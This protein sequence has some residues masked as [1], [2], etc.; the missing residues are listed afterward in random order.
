GLYAEQFAAS[1]GNGDWKTMDEDLGNYYFR[2]YLQL[3]KEAAPEIVSK[4][5]SKLYLDKRK[6]DIDA[7]NNAFTLQSL[8]SLHLVAADGNTSA[9]QTVRIFLIVGI[10]ILCIACIN[11]VN[12]STARSMLRSK[13]VSMRKIIGAARA[14]LFL[15]FIIESV[16]LFIFASALSLLIIYLLL[17]LYNQVSGRQLLFSFSNGGVLTVVACAIIGSLALSGIYPALQLSA[18]KP[19]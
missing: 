11:Y 6:G 19:I 8:S 5:L 4:K 1:G 7:K 13:E 15:Q 9:L 14:Q 16:L 17:P 3:R 12:L 18:F 10:L 2:I